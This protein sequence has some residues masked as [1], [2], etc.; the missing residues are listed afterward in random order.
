MS[1]L[2]DLRTHALRANMV[3]QVFVSTLILLSSTQVKAEEFG[4]LVFNQTLQKIHDYQQPQV[5]DNQERIANLSIQHNK[6]WDNP[7]L[8][9]QQTGFKRRQE[10]SSEVVIS[11][12]I[13]IFGTKRKAAHISE[14]QL[15]NIMLSKQA[16]QVQQFLAVKY[17]WM[18]ILFL[19]Q[20]VSVLKQQSQVSQTNLQ[21]ARYRLQAGSISK[22]DFE[23]VQITDLDLESQ[24]TQQA[25][26]LK[27]LKSKFSKLWGGTTSEFSL[28]EMTDKA[29]QQQA[30]SMSVQENV[31]ESTMQLQKQKY[32]AQ[33]D[34]LKAQAKP[35]PA[36]TLGMVRTQSEFG[37]N[38][39]QQVR[40]GIEI[41]LNIFNREQYSKQIEETK[42]KLLEQERFRYLR[43]QPNDIQNLNAEIKL[44][45]EKLNTLMHDQ[46]PLAEAIQNKMFIGFKAGKYA[47]TEIQLATLELHQRQLQ[48]IEIR[49]NIFQK[50][51][52]LQ[53]LMLGIDAE[54]VLNIDAVNILNKSLSLGMVN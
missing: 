47:V 31:Y 16:Y 33:L 20:E 18:Q 24:Y 37:Q 41:P 29:W 15:Q 27:I 48:E 49:K 36:V 40:V 50:T 17:F 25:L 13:D 3:C 38:A 2:Y 43:Q 22:I 14:I 12:P 30:E 54:T 53:C 42:L 19:E 21:A 1:L 34:Y 9:M 4:T 23:R 51:M 28:K 44:L 26:A 6:L 8:S 10:T 35:K 39:D 32:E 46:I 45:K 7:T 5:W 52:Q 11:Q